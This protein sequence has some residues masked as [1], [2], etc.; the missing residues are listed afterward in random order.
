MDGAGPQLKPEL[1][2]QL[3]TFVE[4]G[5]SP[6]EIAE[7]TRYSESE[8]VAMLTRNAFTHYKRSW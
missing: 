3:L 6:A 5:C 7:L 1:V 8:V 2:E 4:A